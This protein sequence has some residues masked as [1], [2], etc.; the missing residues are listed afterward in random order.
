[1]KPRSAAAP[2]SASAV[3]PVLELEVVAGPTDDCARPITEPGQLL[4]VSQICGQLLAEMLATRQVGV[5]AH[6]ATA[7]AGGEQFR[8]APNSQHFLDPGDYIG[9]ETQ[10][11]KTYT[12]MRGQR[13]PFQALRRRTTKVTRRRL[14]SF[15]FRKRADRRSG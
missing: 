14:R 2:G 5:K 11:L 13:S 10:F 12:V 15:N 8:L 6:L 9:G 1:M 4:P 3:S 7:G